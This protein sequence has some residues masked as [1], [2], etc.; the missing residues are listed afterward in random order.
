MVSKL[1]LLLDD[2]IDGMGNA[3]PNSELCFDGNGEPVQ[4]SQ[5]DMAVGAHSGLFVDLPKFI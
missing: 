2:G 1:F 5:L 4:G 3:C